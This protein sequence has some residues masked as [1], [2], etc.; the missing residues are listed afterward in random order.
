[1][2]HSRVNRLQFSSNDYDEF[3]T[4]LTVAIVEEKILESGAFIGRVNLISSKHVAINQFDINRKVLQIGTGIQGY[5]TFTIWDPKTLFNWRK[6]DMKKG[7]IGVLWNKEHLSITGANFKGLP[8]SVR[9]NFF[10]RACQNKGCHK[11]FDFLK[12]ADVIRVS[13]TKLQNLRIQ[14]RYLSETKKLD[15]QTIYK[16]ME[17]NLVNL[18]IDCLAEYFPTEPKK[19]ITHFKFNS[20][21]EYIHCNLTELTSVNEICVNNQVSERTLRRWFK[22]NYETSPKHYL[23]LLRLNEVRKGIKN[24]SKELNVFQIASEFNFWHMSQF[25]RDYKK[26]FGE[27]PS[28][29]LR[30]S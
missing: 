2:F 1:M 11:L 26:L 22:K 30:N 18:L 6:Y 5:I 15:D 12:K 13:E 23:N 21:I 3:T 29:T 14:I 16:L 10:E 20:V 19:D 17:D 4:K 9:E 7:M 24:N 27:L 8:I 25:S 28:E